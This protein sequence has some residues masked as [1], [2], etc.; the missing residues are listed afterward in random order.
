VNAHDR[1]F[2][3]HFVYLL[4]RHGPE[5]LAKIILDV[6]VRIGFRGAVE[7]AIY[8]HVSNDPQ[9]RVPARAQPRPQLSLVENDDDP[10]PDDAA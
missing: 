4:Q 6:A 2:V 9:R 7:E 3:D 1:R 5:R 10:Q 8:K